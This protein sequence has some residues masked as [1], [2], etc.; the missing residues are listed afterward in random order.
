MGDRIRRAQQGAAGAT[1]ADLTTV[2][3][4]RTRLAVVAEGMAAGTEVVA[5]E[6]ARP[7]AAAILAPSARPRPR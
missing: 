6:A 3:G 2:V 1:N 5:T 4:A 7:R